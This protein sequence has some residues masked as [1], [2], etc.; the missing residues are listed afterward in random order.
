MNE[1]K[2]RFSLFVIMLV[3]VRH[4]PIQRWCRGGM[5]G[6]YGRTMRKV[7]AI[8]EFPDLPAKVNP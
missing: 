8:N 1:K 3:A 2:M 6:R 7:L 5:S 4:I